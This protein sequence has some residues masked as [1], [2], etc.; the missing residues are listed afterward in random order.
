MP[1][2]GD[3]GVEKTFAA[4]LVL[5]LPGKPLPRDSGIL[6]KKLN[7]GGL[8][9]EIRDTEGIGHGEGLGEPS[10][11]R[12]DL[13]EFR[14]NARREAKGFSGQGGLRG[15]RA[16]SGVVGVLGESPCDKETGIESDHVQSPR[17]IKS[18]NISALPPN[19]SRMAPTNMGEGGAT[20]EGR[21]AESPTAFQGRGWLPDSRNACAGVPDF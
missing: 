11:V 20:S 13:D 10:R 14:Q 12:G 19:G 2:G 7:F 8:G 17:S 4:E 15:K 21:S 5:S 1:S 9:S 6:V 18:A 16:A 3:E